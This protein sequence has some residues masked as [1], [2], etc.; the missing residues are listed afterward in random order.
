M[1]NLKYTLVALLI[2]M[3]F[4]LTAY[5][6]RL[7]KENSRLGDNQRAL[8]DSV[9]HYKTRAGLSAASVEK[10]TLTKSELQRYNSE[11]A[12]TVADLNIKLKRAQ[13]VSR[14]AIKT[15]YDIHT[16]VK[17]SIIYHVRD[18]MTITFDTVRCVDY[19]DAW[20]NLR[21][22]Y[23]NSQADFNITVRDTIVQVVHRIPKRFLFFRFGCKAIRQEV[24]TK[25]PHTEISYTEYIE[26]K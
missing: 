16:V 7:R 13:S 18:S 11:L 2:I 9:T 21:G 17:D 23:H 10:L 6:S 20:L 26:I 1:I 5:N 15:Q 8:F 22:C 4:L 14:T 12:E 25:N 3:A 24:V 19:R